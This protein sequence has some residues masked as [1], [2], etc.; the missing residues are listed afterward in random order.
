VKNQRAAGAQDV[1]DL[2]VAVIELYFR[3]EAVTQAIAGF[4][5]AG[6]EWG[7]LRSLVLEG[8]QTVPELARA[9]PVSR[10]YCQTIVNALA[11]QNFVEFA[12]NPRHRKSHLVRA[13]KQGRAQYDRMTKQFLAAAAAYAP[14]FTEKELTGAI[15]V[16]RRA[17]ELISV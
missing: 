14:H 9:R 3:L 12:P 7:V 10:Q 5:Q 11:A 2:S 4:A 8:E 15:S 16:C 1:L 17:R 6:G 13:T